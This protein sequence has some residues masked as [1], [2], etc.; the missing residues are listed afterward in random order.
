MTRHTN[1]LKQQIERILHWEQPSHWRFRDFEFLS[2]LVFA[3]THRRV[4]ALDLQAFWES[5][6]IPSQPFLDS[7]ACFADYTDWDDFCIRNF[8]GVVETDDEI[9]TLHARHWE[10]PVQWVIVICW[11]SVLASV[12]VGILL[13]WKR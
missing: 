6:A 10:I 4:D 11:L 1:D 12:L 13:V 2:Q 7:L 8:Y 9:V 3:R 5:S